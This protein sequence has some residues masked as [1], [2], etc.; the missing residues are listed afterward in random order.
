ML[1]MKSSCAYPLGKWECQAMVL[2]V[3]RLAKNIPS[4]SK[5]GYLLFC[6]PTHE[7]VQI[8]G[9]LLI[10]N[11]MDQSLWVA[12]SEVGISSQIIFITLFSRRCKALVHFLPAS[13]NCANM[14][15]RPKPFSRG[16]GFSG[17]WAMRSVES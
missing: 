1:S 17:F 6:N 16:M 10:A 11:H 4:R 8:G 12:H 3:C 9:R 15:G 14:L 7:E 5:F 2:S 13:A